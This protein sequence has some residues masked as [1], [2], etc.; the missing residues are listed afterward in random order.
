MS[1]H[2]P[3][4]YAVDL[5]LLTG[6]A[7]SKYFADT[8]Y[9]AWH[10]ALPATPAFTLDEMRHLFTRGRVVPHHTYSMQQ[11]DF[12]RAGFEVTKHP[13]AVRLLAGT[14]VIGLGTRDRYDIFDDTEAHE[15]ITYESVDEWRANRDA[16]REGFR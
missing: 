12:D 5:N 8:D 9:L 14:L 15:V 13:W 1:E 16:G 11:S 4:I 3:I 7:P 10:A 2:R 6:V